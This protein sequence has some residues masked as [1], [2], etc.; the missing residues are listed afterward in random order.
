LESLVFNLGSLIYPKDML[1]C[2]TKEHSDE[3]AKE[4]RKE[5]KDKSPEAKNVITVYH[6]LYRFSLQRLYHFVS[7]PALVL[8]FDYYYN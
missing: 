4:L 7:E 1:K 8:L 6:Y 3:L 2:Y 5:I